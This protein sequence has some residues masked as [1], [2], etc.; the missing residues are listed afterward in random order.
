VRRRLGEVEED[1]PA[2]AGGSVLLLGHG[3][4]AATALGWLAA[5]AERSRGTRVTWAVRSGNRRPCAEIAGDPLPERRRVSAAAND[6]AASPPEFLRVER[7]AALESLSEEGV[8]LHAGLS[9]GRGGAF[10]AVIALT[11]YRP[12]W[13]FVSELTLEIS[14][15]TEGARGLSLALGRGGDCLSAPAVSERDLGSG[16]PGFFAI[17]AKSY[18]RSRQFLLRTGLAHL[19]AILDILA[20]PTAGASVGGPAARPGAVFG[21]AGAVSAGS[22]Q[23]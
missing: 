10:D 17:G 7:R 14:A 16:E 13:S 18:G 2:M 12:D 6:L 3:H 11:G 15:A 19:Q 8:R 20:G 4:S 21:K 1:L 5:L 23:R 22:D 9:G